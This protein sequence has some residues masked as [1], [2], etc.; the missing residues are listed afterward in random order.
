MSVT[1]LLPA[2]ARPETWRYVILDPS[3]RQPP[4]L[5]HELAY[6][7]WKNIWS[8][9]FREVEGRSFVE[10]DNFSRQDEI[11]ALFAGERCLM[12]SGF[13]EVSLSS[14]CIRDD[15]Y[16][17]PWSDESLAELTKDGDQILIGNQI[18]VD[19]EARGKNFPVSM[20]DLI[21]ALSILRLL[22]SECAA[23]AGTMRNLKGMN[24]LALR[25][26]ATKIP[27]ELELHGETSEIFAFYRSSYEQGLPQLENL[28]NKL[29]TERLDLTKNGKPTYREKKIA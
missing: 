14:Q 20:K 16:F 1:Y 4:S 21:V 15:S 8:A 26:R 11:G 22:D 24:T 19:P 10:S 25:H 12:L 28:S 29:W 9:T 5:H 18:T 2:W 6:R 27:Q 3:P 23:M 7:F 17:A 13:R